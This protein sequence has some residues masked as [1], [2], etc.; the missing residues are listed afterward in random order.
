VIPLLHPLPDPLDLAR[1]DGHIVF[2]GALNLNLIATRYAHPAGTW[3]DRLHAAWETRPDV[4]H[5]TSWPCSTI[6]GP[7]YLRTPMNP[8]GCAIIAPGQW[9]GSHAPGL[10]NGRRALVQVGP[11]GVYRDNDRDGIPEPS[12]EVDIG[13][14]GVNVHDVGYGDPDPGELAGC[15]GLRGPDMDD[16]LDIVA[17]CGDAR[18]PSGKRYGTRTSLTLIDVS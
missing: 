1:A 16:L 5:V 6:P 8:K 9:R 3:G 12:A 4:W 15:V 13:M 18:G 17:M 10:H 7:K 2:R 14:H 11:V